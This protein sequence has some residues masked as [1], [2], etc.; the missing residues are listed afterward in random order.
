[1]KSLFNTELIRQT[2]EDIME[3]GLPSPK[4]EI[5]ITMDNNGCWVGILKIHGTEKYKSA[6]YGNPEKC[7]SHIYRI[8]ELGLGRVW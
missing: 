5:V 7:L 8:H 2:Y 3:N 4:V 1:M 6:P